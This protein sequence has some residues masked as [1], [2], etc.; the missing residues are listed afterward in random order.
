MG[1]GISK[2]VVDSMVE[3]TNTVINNYEQICTV[4]GSSSEA[5]F[6]ANG[7]NFTGTTINI[8]DTQTITQQCITN[9]ITKNSIT[10]SINQSMKQSAT[11]VT[12]S[13]GFPTLQLAENFINASTRL[14]NEIANRYNLTCSA[15]ASNSTATF[16]CQNS[17][18]NNSIVNV[19]SY[20]QITQK[21]LQQD[22]TINDLKS[23]VVAAL[24]QS[25]TSQQANTFASVVFI[26]FIIIFIIA[27][28]GISIADSPAVQIGIV[29]LVTI[30]VISTAVYSAT[31]QNRG[32]Y[33]YQKP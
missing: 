23:D 24:N 13:F 8:V 21:C 7:C 10:S 3:N 27:Y 15:E 18:F 20:Q 28:L 6:K 33:P 31:A 14:G 22:Q 1:A 32:N 5:Q 2:N 12:Q 30:S 26:F 11:A 17:N 19:E 25:T 9:D 4:G 16:E 29:L